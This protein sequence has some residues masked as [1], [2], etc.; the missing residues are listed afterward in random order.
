MSPPCRVRLTVFPATATLLRVH[1]STTQIPC[2]ARG[3]CC[4]VVCQPLEM[5]HRQ[6]RIYDCRLQKGSSVNC[7][8]ISYNVGI[9]TRFDMYTVPIRN[10]WY[11][12]S[13]YPNSEA[14]SIEDAM[15]EWQNNGASDA[16]GTVA[17]IVGLGSTEAGLLY[18][19]PTYQPASFAPVYELGGG[20]IAIPPTNG[21]LISLITI[22]GASLAELIECH[23]YRAASSKIDAQLYK[24]VYTFWQQDASAVY[25]ATGAN[26]TFVIQP[27]PVSVVQAGN[28]KAGN[29][30]G[31]PNE[32]FQC[33]T[34]LIDW[35]DTSQDNE[36]R[37]ASIATTQKW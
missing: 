11:S 35:S 16:L 14:S 3:S 5:S 8:L 17:L 4:G 12:V 15:V 9:V 13:V 33:W 32:S 21:T 1:D 30:L 20:T 22:F 25:N 7:R 28:A 34:T 26:Q 19:Q 31:M 6:F 29:A 18:A 37:S 36:V 24:D 27:V 23:D 10:I 2:P